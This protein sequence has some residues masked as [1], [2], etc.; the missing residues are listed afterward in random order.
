[1]KQKKTTEDIV[2][3]VENDDEEGL[4]QAQTEL[5]KARLNYSESKQKKWI[6]V[7]IGIILFS[8]LSYFLCKLIFNFSKVTYNRTPLTNFLGKNFARIQMTEVAT[9]EA[10]IIGYEYNKQEPRFYTKNLTHHNNSYEFKVSMPEAIAGACSLL[11]YFLPYNVQ[12]DITSKE[13]IVDGAI[14]AEN[15]SFYSAILAKEMMGK[16][17]VRVVSVGA[18][19]SNFSDITFKSGGFVL[20]LLQD[21]NNIIDYFNYVKARSHSYL[22]KVVLKIDT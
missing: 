19:Y 18:G 5:D 8:V 6:I 22:T 14:I 4:K 17:H 20:S 21:S 11:D 16:K 2:K 15:P 1:M 12:L 3:M 9:D 7:A 10:L 13:I